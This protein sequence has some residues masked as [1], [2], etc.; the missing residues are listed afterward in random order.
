MYSEAG[1]EAELPK[2]K[3]LGQEEV[4]AYERTA[5]AEGDAM[6]GDA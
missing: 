6:E 3:G 2:T 1:I 5:E 4:V